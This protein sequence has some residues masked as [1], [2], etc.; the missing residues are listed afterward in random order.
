M[1]GRVRHGKEVE[2]DD[3][4]NSEDRERPELPRE[5]GRGPFLDCAGDLLHVLGALARGE[6][7]TGQ[8]ERDSDGSHR[9]KGD[10]DQDRVVQAGDI[11]SA[12][13]GAQRPGHACS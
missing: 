2:K 3:D 13:K 5:V 4:Q 11:H 7:L 6:D 1:I 8:N 12:E 10:D 9:D